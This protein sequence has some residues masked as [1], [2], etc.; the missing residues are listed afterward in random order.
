MSTRT[1]R[2]MIFL[3]PGQLELREVPIPKPADGE[4]LIKIGC[5]TTCGTDLKA[6]KRGYRLP[7]Y[8]CHAL[9]AQR[10]AGIFLR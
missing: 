7:A 1:M 9:F 5:A 4:I 2:A 10:E 8:V 3:G 6:F